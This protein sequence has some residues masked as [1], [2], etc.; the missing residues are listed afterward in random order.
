MRAASEAESMMVLATFR[1]P[2]LNPL[3]RGTSGGAT[4]YP[5]IVALDPPP[6][7]GWEWALEIARRL[8]GR[9]KA[10]KVGWPLLLEGNRVGELKEFGEVIADLKLADIGYTMVN[11]VKRVGADAYI[12]HAFVG[13][14]ALRELREEVKRLY[15]VV[16]MSHEGSREFIDLHWRE[17]VL[18]A[19]ELADGIVAPA[20][21]PKVI[22]KIRRIW[23]REIISPGIGAQGAHP[24]SAIRAGADYEIVG[25][26]LTRARDPLEFLEAHY[27]C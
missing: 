25:R 12:A 3:W 9:V 16:S 21:R 18:E 2:K 8:K 10:F 14:D 27:P 20:T 23:P 26:S 11:V 13:R 1:A 17:F 24:C 6:N 19:Y 22:E 15:L 5:V 4:F 7:K